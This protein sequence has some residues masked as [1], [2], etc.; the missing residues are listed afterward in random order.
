[1]VIIQPS[2]I[3]FSFRNSYLWQAPTQPWTLCSAWRYQTRHAFCFS[4]AYT[5]WRDDIIKQRTTKIYHKVHG[6]YYA[7]E[8][9]RNPK[10][11]GPSS[12]A[13]VY[14]T[15]PR[16]PMHTRVHRNGVPWN[17][18]VHNLSSHTWQPWSGLPHTLPH[19]ICIT[20]LEGKQGSE[21]LSSFSEITPLVKGRI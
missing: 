13:V 2:H 8:C 10:E 14:Y 5:H 19:L 20:V 1:M 12:C 6:F 4:V 17:G 16:S 11:G 3:L 21:R 7:L 9:Y 18:A 15:T